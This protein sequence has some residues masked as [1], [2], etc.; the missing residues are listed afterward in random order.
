MSSHDLEAGR[1]ARLRQSLDRAECDAGLFYDPTNIRYATGTSNMQV[2]SLHNPCRYVYVP[3]NGPV[4]LFDFKGCAHL[5]DQHLGV[6][7]VRDATS[8]YDFITGGR[9]NEFARRWADEISA[10]IGP[11]ERRLAVDR[12]DPIGTDA[13]RNLGIELCDGQRVAN[14]ARMIKTTH[15]V[16]AI[17]V[18]IDACEAAISE[19]QVAMRPGISE[20]ELWAE[21]HRANIAGGGEWLE[22]RLLT[23]GIRTNPWY[24][25]C[26]AKTIEQGDLVAF[27]TDLIGVGGY[28]VDMSRTWVAG[29]AV[30]SANQQ[31]LFDAAFE[32]LKENTALIRP[33]ASFAEISQA[34]HIPDSSIHSPTNAAVAHGIGLCNEYPLILNRDHFARGGYD[35]E[36]AAGMVLCVEA[37]A[38]PVG[39]AEA[40]KLEDQILVTADGPEVLSGFSLDLV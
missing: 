21:L 1:L 23:S 14:Q 19:M 33:G 20:R 15:E 16:A 2:Y 24:Q 34:A 9:T 3:T 40:V 4:V 22:T 27:D 13:L 12:L 18:A 38:A 36:V 17:R 32:Q 37:L 10:L 39:G 5:S 30:P 35:G 11:G 28:S 26:S 6:N 7:E 31:R 25:E 29:N 8:W